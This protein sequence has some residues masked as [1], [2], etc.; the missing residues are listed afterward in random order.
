MVSSPPRCSR[1]PKDREVSKPSHTQAVFRVTTFA[2]GSASGPTLLPESEMSQRKRT[3]EWSEKQA[4]ELMRGRILKGIHSGQL[5]TG[6]RLPTYREVSEETGLDLRAVT[7]VYRVLASEGLVEIRGRTGVYVAPQER[8]GGRVLAETARWVIGVLR[9]VWIRQIHLPDFP[10]FLRKCIATAEV[11]CVCIEST[12]DQLERICTEL[13]QDFGFRAISIHADRLAPIRSGN[14]TSRERVPRELGEAH[15]LVTTAFHAAAVRPM[16]QA[17]EKPLAV[18][19]LTPDLVR[20][21][22]KHLAGGGLTVI[23]VDPRFLERVRLTVGGEHGDRIRGVLA[24]DEEAIR[25]LDR[26]KPVLITHAARERLP[27]LDLPSIIP[28]GPILSRESAEEL[29][30]LLVRFNLEAMRE[31]E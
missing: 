18:V 25:H 27:E 6:D 17:L 9:E 12:V 3:R 10:E 31:K 4:T 30:E 2:T 14:G 8:L 11:R 19:R 22:E 7:R 24:Q 1:A 13:H 26:S 20:E 29:A 5:D 23:C 21:V 15:F 16:A 28:P